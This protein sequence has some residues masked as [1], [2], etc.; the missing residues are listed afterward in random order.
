[1]KSRIISIP[2]E[3][4]VLLI[5]VVFLSLAKIV[6]FNSLSL[7]Y[8]LW[9]I[10]LAVIPFVISSVLLWY[11]NNKKLTKAT[12]LIGGLLWILIL[13]NAPYIVTDMVHVNHGHTVS[14]LYDT[15]L[16][17]S[18]ACVGLLLSMY[19]ISHIERIIRSKYSKNITLSIV[20]CIILVTSFGMYLGRFLRFNSWDVFS[21]SSFLFKEIWNIVSKPAVNLDAYFFTG[22]SFVFISMAY[23]AW[24]YTQPSTS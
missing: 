23:I 12:F 13:P 10:F 14:V 4:S 16:L 20:F 17:F 19:S 6:I 18:S 3:I 1:M 22:L 9:N 24:K 7:L 21:N 8:L 11:R 2:R 15:F 5:L